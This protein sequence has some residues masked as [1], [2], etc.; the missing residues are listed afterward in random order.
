MD[1]VID[2]SK[3]LGLKAVKGS[4]DFINGINRLGGK[5]E[6]KVTEAFEKYGGV[7]KETIGKVLTELKPV[8]IDQE[9]PESGQDFGKTI[10]EVFDKLPIVLL[11]IYKN[12]LDSY[13]D[14]IGRQ[15][16]RI[17]AVF[18]QTRRETD[19]FIKKNSY[20]VAKELYKESRNS[21]NSWINDLLTNGL[22]EDGKKVAEDL[23]G[24][25]GRHLL[26]MEAIF[27]N[28]IRYNKGRFLDAVKPEV[29]EALARTQRWDNE[30]KMLL[31]KGRDLEETLRQRRSDV[32]QLES[33]LNEAFEKLEAALR[34]LP[35][36]VQQE[37]RPSIEAFKDEKV[38][39]LKTALEQVDDITDTVQQQMSMDKLRQDFDRRALLDALRR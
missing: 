32:H 17:I 33:D 13:R 25:L 3:V 20:E 15:I 37:F 14:K 22:K 1:N 12:N 7:N 27:D 39:Q 11:G 6:N 34:R 2:Q 24:G 16:D 28:F 4:I 35:E 26:D 8:F 36:E 10:L 23:I 9:L 29:E 38:R 30:L 31:S 21:L 19:E 5:L 18:Q